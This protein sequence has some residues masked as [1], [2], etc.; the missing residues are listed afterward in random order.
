MHG[1]F[2]YNVKIVLAILNWW[3]GWWTLFDIFTVRILASVNCTQ[4]HSY[5]LN[6][7]SHVLAHS[8]I[9]FTYIHLKLIGVIVIQDFC[10][11]CLQCCVGAY[12]GFLKGVFTDKDMGVSPSHWKT[13]NFYDLHLYWILTELWLRLA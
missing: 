6:F 5:T 10:K 7:I 11:W 3:K 9:T 1:S 2:I 8:T 13:F 12:P 4:Q